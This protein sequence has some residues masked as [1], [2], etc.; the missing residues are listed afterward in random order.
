ML[1]RTH[2]LVALTSLTVSTILAA[3]CSDPEPA[4]PQV[5]FDGQLQLTAG[6]DPNRGCKEVGTLF[7]V[8]DFGNVFTD[9]KTPSRPVQDGA[10]EQQG[11]VSIS[12]SVTP[13][14]ADEFNVNATVRLT[15]ATGGLFTVKGKFKTGGEQTGE[16]IFAKQS[17]SS[18]TQRDGKCVVKYTT[19]NQGVAAGRIWGEITCPNA[20]LANGDSSCQGYAQFRFENCAQ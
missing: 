2:A 17:L 12:C 16:G 3:G 19:P 4:I 7:T 9:P 20:E 13:A 14:G 8:G 18:Y 1:R 15:G 10:Q 11:S 6:G 5:I